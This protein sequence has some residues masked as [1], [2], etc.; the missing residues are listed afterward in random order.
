MDRFAGDAPMR[1]D[2]TRPGNG[3]DV[4]DPQSLTE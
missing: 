1:E 3:P 2:L 4:D